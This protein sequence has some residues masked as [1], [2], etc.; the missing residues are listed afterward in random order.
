MQRIRR[1]SAQLSEMPIAQIAAITCNINRDSKKQPKP[2]AL[3]DFLLFRDADA[4][5][6]EKAVLSPVV[7]AAMLELRHRDDLT[8]LLM[9]AWPQAVA[10]ATETAKPPET[11]ALHSDDGN[12][13]IVAPAWEGRNIRG[14]L[15]AVNGVVHGKIKVRDLTRPLIVHELVLPKRDA[16]AWLEAGV[17]LVQA[18]T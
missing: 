7:A 17:L 15:V 5:R 10:S 1:E 16:A 18:E 13:W 14:G 8:S 12:V 6:K 2:F 3:Q 9:V 11:L 4:D